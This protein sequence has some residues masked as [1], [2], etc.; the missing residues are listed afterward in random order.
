LLHEGQGAVGLDPEGGRPV[1]AQAGKHRLT[2]DHDRLKRR[3]SAQK[4]V[5]DSA[6]DTPEN[7]SGHRW[8]HC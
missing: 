7:Q 6:E 8:R 5:V 2:R 1:P 3:Q 4:G